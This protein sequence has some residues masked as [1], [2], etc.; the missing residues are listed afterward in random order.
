MRAISRLSVPDTKSPGTNSAVI[1]RDRLDNDNQPD[2]RGANVMMEELDNTNPLALPDSKKSK[3]S[4]PANIERGIRLDNEKKEALAELDTQ[5]RDLLEKLAIV[6]G[7]HDDINDNRK[8]KYS[9]DDDGDTKPAS[10]P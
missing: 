8:R 6:Q 2:D 1:Y 10:K 9:D 4:V 3:R 7:K 5:K